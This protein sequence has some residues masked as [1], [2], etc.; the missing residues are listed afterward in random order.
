MNVIMFP[1]AYNINKYMFIHF[2]TLSFE[3]RNKETKKKGLANDLLHSFIAIFPLS[4]IF[5]ELNYIKYHGKKGGIKNWFYVLLIQM[6]FQQNE[7]LIIPFF[8]VL[9]SCYVFLGWK[10]RSFLVVLT[11]WNCI[12]NCAIT[13]LTESDKKYKYI[14]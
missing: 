14:F 7:S 10:E 13:G 12:F 4:S 3:F 9:D 5:M 11:T 1:S 6:W 8:P 2:A